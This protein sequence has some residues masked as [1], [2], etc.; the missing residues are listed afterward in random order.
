MSRYD[1]RLQSPI[2]SAFAQTPIVAAG[3]VASIKAGEP[4]KTAAAG[5]VA[6]MVDADGT[7]TQRFSGVAK[8]DSSDTVAAAGTVQVWLPLPGMIF[9]AKAKTASLANTQALI[10]GLYGKRVIF[11]LTGT[12]WT[13]DSVAVDAATNCVVILGGEFQTSTL[14]FAYS[15]SG[16][17]LE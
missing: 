2:E 6:I 11:D 17:V 10:D 8:S 1:I 5:A 16:T 14:Y 12:A 15:I 3:V 4:T 13:V 9:A 7:T